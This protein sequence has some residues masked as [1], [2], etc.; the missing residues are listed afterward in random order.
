M[1]NSPVAQSIAVQCHASRATFPRWES[2]PTYDPRT[3]SSAG[4]V[5]S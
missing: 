1:T 4:A 5:R 2:W 3:S